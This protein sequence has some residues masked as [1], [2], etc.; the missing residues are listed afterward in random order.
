[1]HVEDVDLYNCFR[2]S[3]VAQ[4]KVEI[5]VKRLPVGCVIYKK[6]K[7]LWT[8]CLCSQFTSALWPIIFNLLQN[9]FFD[10]F[11]FRNSNLD[12]HDVSQYQFGISCYLFQTFYWINFFSSCVSMFY[13]DIFLSSF[14][15][16]KFHSNN[17]IK[18]VERFFF[19]KSILIMLSPM[20]IES[21]NQSN[22]FS[23][24][25]W[26][27]FYLLNIE[28]Q[29]RYLLNF[30]DVSKIILF[31]DSTIPRKY[32]MFVRMSVDKILISF[33]LIN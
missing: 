18:A 9:L 2:K 3:D 29:I 11:I 21:F 22:Q 30:S 19:L 1:M 8:H 17:N 16:S 12:N 28:I 32:N 31:S 5:F 6:K 14:N 13:A 10:E 7:I 4:W 15:F 24:W 23:F 33:V 27:C 25:S 26:Q 20:P